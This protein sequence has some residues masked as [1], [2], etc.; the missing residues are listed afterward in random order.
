MKEQLLERDRQRKIAFEIIEKIFQ[1][2]KKQIELFELL[3]FSTQSDLCIPFLVNQTKI[4][5]SNIQRQLAILLKK[6]LIVRKPITIADYNN[7]CVQLLQPEAQ[8]PGSKG[9]LYLYSAVSNKELMDLI[10]TQFSEW[11]KALE[12]FFL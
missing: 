1:L 9:Y 7:R 11:Q 3:F 2:N 5:R 8:N 12:S 4:E 10:K 6:G